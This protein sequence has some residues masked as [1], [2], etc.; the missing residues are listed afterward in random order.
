MK[1]GIFTFHC[2]INYGAVLQAYSLQEYLKEMGH[3]VYIINYRPDYLL[4][5]YRIFRWNEFPKE[6]VSGLKWLVR[7][8]MVIPIRW[9]RKVNFLKFIKK[10]LCL[11]NLDLNNP[12]NDFDAFVFGSDQIWNPL[13]TKGVDPVF[14]GKFP[15]ACNK[16][17]YS[18]A[19]SVG[20]VAN[21]T[22]SQLSELNKGIEVFDKIGVR[23]KHLI[24]ILHNECKLNYTIDPVLLM[25]ARLFRNKIPKIDIKKPFVL[26][27][28]L[29]RE[30]YV[31]ERARK[32][33]SK[34]K[35]DIIEVLSSRESI[36]NLN[37][38]QTLSPLDLLSYIAA[39]SYVITSSYHG[40]L[41]SILFEKEFNYVFN[42]PNTASRSL[43]ILMELGIVDHAVSYKDINRNDIKC[44]DYSMVMKRITML[45]TEVSEFWKSNIS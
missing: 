37:I 14:V 29:G 3:E 24:N 28:T 17:L 16:K 5:P 11:Y 22:T 43:D 8:L 20:S 27:F 31:V 30:E 10:H 41:L 36:F 6:P 38:R 1:I 2:A 9:K 32:I 42:N 13:I 15:A 18:Y 40:M 44:I 33:A 39:S 21:L 35:I 25:D 26:L 23:E 12:N 45:R 34:S 7:E 19:A 4:Y